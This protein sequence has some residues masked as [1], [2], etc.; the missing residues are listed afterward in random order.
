MVAAIVGHHPPPLLEV[1]DLVF[2]VGELAHG[3]VEEDDGGALRIIP[4]PGRVEDVEAQSLFDLNA[5]DLD[6]VPNALAIAC[7]VL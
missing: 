5:L 2:P 3:A 6:T 1:L 4:F 7:R